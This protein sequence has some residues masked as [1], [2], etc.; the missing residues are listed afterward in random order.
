MAQTYYEILGVADSASAAEIEAAFKA[1]AREV[2]PDRVEPGSPYLQQVAAEAFKDLA[3][4]KSVLLDPVKKT[5]IRFGTGPTTQARGSLRG[6]TRRSAFVWMRAAAV[7]SNST[8]AAG[9]TVWPRTAGADAILVLEAT[10]CAFYQ[11][12]IG[13]IGLERGFRSGRSHLERENSAIVGGG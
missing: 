5:K 9:H 4:A 12:S 6:G 3:E 10:E 1:R 11:R 13:R 8:C 2:H 7:P